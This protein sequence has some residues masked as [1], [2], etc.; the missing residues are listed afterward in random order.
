[1]K[2][3]GIANLPLHYGKA[4]A[5]LFEK[6]VSLSKN[7]ISWI[8]M[9]EG[10]NS[11][12]E[13]IS[14]PFWFQSFGCVLGF[15]WHSSGLT[16]TVCGAI[17]EA[18]KDIGR[19][20]GIYMAGGKG[21][22][23]RRTPEEIKL[24]A[25]KKGLNPENLIYASKI[26]AKVDT[27]AVQDGYSLYH[28]A[29]I[30][31]DSGNWA[32]IQQGMNEENRM[33]R[34]YH[35]LSLKIKDFVNE[36]HYAVCCDERHPLLNMVAKESEFTRDVITHISKESPDKWVKE[37]KKLKELNLPQE[38]YVDIGQLNLERLSKI[39]T[40]IHEIPPENFEKLISIEGIG[41]ATVRALALI[42]DIVYGAKPSFKDPATYSFA[43]GGKDGHPFPVERK[44]YEKSIEIIERAIKFAKI[45]DYEKIRALRRLR[46]YFT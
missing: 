21:K 18:T 4:P 31:N 10:S 38:H 12:L 41:P 19:D 8:C 20:F 39:L 34:R 33:A 23:A 28:H 29:F 9:E 27:V 44:T 42:S 16:T 24:L 15:D 26:S 11:F 2:K 43:H 6:M 3:I 45:G 25:E 13:K 22:V 5:W 36:P 1:M 7:I 46:Y 35:W 37:F 32:V 14:D 40:K 17:K 30:F